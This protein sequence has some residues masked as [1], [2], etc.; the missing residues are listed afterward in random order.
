MLSKGAST[1][2]AP[3]HVSKQNNVEYIQKKFFSEGLNFFDA[4]IFFF[5]LKIVIIRM[6]R[7]RA[8]TPPNLLGMDRKIA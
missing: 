2:F 8:V 5:A 1:G 4:T 7:I 6:E 3:I